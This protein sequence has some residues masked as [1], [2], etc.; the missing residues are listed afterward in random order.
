MNM[1]CVFVNTEQ[2]P[3]KIKRLG[4]FR[5]EVRGSETFVVEMCEV[6]YPHPD[7]PEHAIISVYRWLSVEF[8]YG[9]DALIKQVV[10]AMNAIGKITKLKE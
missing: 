4:F 8:T 2:E 10:D 7:A 1:Q 5:Y 3:T 9:T 6:F